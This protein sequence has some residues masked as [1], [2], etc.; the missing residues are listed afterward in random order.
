MI[1]CG[2]VKCLLNMAKSADSCSR[3][4][5]IEEGGVEAFRHCNKIE[6]CCEVYGQFT[7]SQEIK[8]AEEVNGNGIRVWSLVAS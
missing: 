8:R 7:T 2:F 4:R 1:K 5:K 6:N 3:Q